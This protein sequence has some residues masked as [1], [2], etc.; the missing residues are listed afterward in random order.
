MEVCSA[1]V[2][3]GKESVL[4]EFRWRKMRQWSLK[5]TSERDERVASVE[6]LAANVLVA[7]ARLRVVFF[8]SLFVRA[9]DVDDVDGERPRS[10]ELALLSGSPA[11]AECLAKHRL[12][13]ALREAADLAIG[14]LRAFSSA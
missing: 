2:N 10:T 6:E 9:R 4:A 11:R 7:L 12:R 1:A 3:S 8:P 13:D 14:R 5:A